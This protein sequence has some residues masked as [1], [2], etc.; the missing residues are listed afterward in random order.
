MEN[1]LGQLQKFKVLRETQIGFMLT[2]NGEDEF[3]LHKNETNFRH[4]T[5]GE[6]VTGFLYSDKKARIAV[7]LVTP[8]VTTEKA[9]FAKVIEVSTALG[10]F[11]DIGISKDILLSKDDLPIDYKEWP[12]VG[13]VLLCILKVKGDRLIAKMLNKNEILD[14]NLQFDLPLNEKVPGYVYRI[15]DDGINIVTKTLNVVFVYKSHMRKKYRLGEEVNV[16]IVKQNIDD[17]NGTLIESKEDLIRQDRDKILS[18][19]N[20]ND[21]IMSITEKSDPAVIYKVFNMS[22]SAFKNAIGSLYKERLIEIFD[23]KIVLL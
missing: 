3:F 12:E 23:E 18:Y 2:I 1:K 15:S 20:S 17:Y 10:A 7:T 16:K 8:N 4:L 9:G 21:G 19:L 5:E 13:D 11:L 6:E 22:K 14:L